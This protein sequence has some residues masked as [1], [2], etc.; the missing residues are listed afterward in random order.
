MQTLTQS[1]E[2]MGSY[3]LADLHPPPRYTHCTLHPVKL[4]T[5]TPASRFV[6][7]TKILIPVNLR[8]WT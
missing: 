8:T 6:D 7:G 5:S 4:H 1:F 3:I 2:F